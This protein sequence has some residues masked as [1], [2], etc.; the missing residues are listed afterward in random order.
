MSNI[1]N[2]MLPGGGYILHCAEECS[3]TDKEKIFCCY[4]FLFLVSATRKTPAAEM[5]LARLRRA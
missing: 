2:E 1:A 4:I 3:E 5:R